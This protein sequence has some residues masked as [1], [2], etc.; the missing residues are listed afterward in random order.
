[1]TK[2]KIAVIG[3]KG[4]PA[5]GGAAAVGENI[6]E[7]LK[8]NYD[9]TIYA[10]SSHANFEDKEINGI[11]QI[12]FHRIPFKRINALY[13]YI[14]SALHCLI[15]G[16]YDLIHLHHSDAA[17]II[18]IL[19]KKAPVII[20]THG[21]ST[22]ALDDEWRKLKFYFRIQEKYFVKMANKIC[23]VSIQEENSFLDDYDIKAEY[24]PNGVNITEPIKK[25]VKDYILFAAGRIIVR[26]G[27]ITFLKALIKIDYK[28]NVKIAGSLEY[29]LELKKKVLKLSKSLNIDFLGLIK[30]KSELFT[31][32]ANAKL[33]IFPSTREGMSM[34]L[35]EVAS[36]KTPTIASNIRQNTDIFNNN[37][38]LF[39][40]T[41]DIND[42]SNKMIW[43]SN[44]GPA[45]QQKSESAFMKL[46]K[47]FTWD[48]IS[49]KYD[50]I[51]QDLMKEI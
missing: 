3:L 41:G 19:K 43:A 31:L 32:I 26:K 15:K 12:I 38:I 42:L 21:I 5:F 24:I 22:T 23:C 14:V 50:I 2:K 48:K 1:M 37:E 45:M 34:M 11:K 33:F 25:N 47:Q 10:I 51:Y 7:Q 49:S 18:P 20:T 9:F 29:N 8:A 36:L 27:I 35:L 28:G 44:N 46:K 40:N 17:F 30:N 13:Y 39:F 6:I 4:L 16:E